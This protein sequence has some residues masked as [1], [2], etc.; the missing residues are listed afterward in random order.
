MTPGAMTFGRTS[1]T[2]LR[3]WE[4]RLEPAADGSL[5]VPL[6]FRVVPGSWPD[7]ELAG[8]DGTRADVAAVMYELRVLCDPGARGTLDIRVGRFDIGLVGRTLT[9]DLGVVEVPGSGPIEIGVFFDGD[10][11]AVVVDGGEPLGL[12]ALEDSSTTAVAPVTPNIAGFRTAT[13]P[14]ANGRVAI[15]GATEVLEAKI[16]GLRE[17]ETSLY[18]NAARASGAPGR[19][20]WSEAGY[21]V[22]DASVAV[23]G[24]GPPALVPDCRTIVSPVRV[25]EEF[26]WRDTAYGDMTRVVDRSEMWRSVVEP[27]RFPTFTSSFRSIDAAFELALETFQRNSSD[28]FS[29]PGETGLWSAGYF[30]GPGLGFGSWKRDTSHIALRAGNLIDPQVARASLA[31]VGHAGFDNGSD[32]ASLPAVA[33]WDHFLATGDESLIHDTWRWLAASASL[34]DE[35]FDEGRGLVLAAQSTSNDLFD[36]PEAGGYALSTEIYSMETYR[37][38]AAMGSLP[39]IGDPR[40][41]RWSERATTMR[42]AILA[43]YWNSERGYFTSG[44]IG[45]ESHKRGLWE[46]SGSEAAVWGFLGAEAESCTESV[47]AGM[48]HVAM[49]QYGV[50]LFPYKD[51]DN[52]FCHSVWYCWQAGFARAAARVGDASLVHQLIGQQARTAVLYKTF[53]EVTDARTGESW[54]WPGQLWHAAGFVSLVLFGLFGIRYDQ[55]GMTFSPA[56]SPEFDGARIYG[57]RYRAAVLDIEIRGH[58]SRCETTFD[59]DRVEQVSTDCTGRHSV[60]LTMTM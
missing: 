51:A 30:Q 3:V 59:G 46:T 27:G 36:E 25:I 17:A 6:R 43:Q 18:R 58:G 57:L 38:L 24:G 42:R 2:S 41:Q 5:T 48:R 32:G 12:L 56:V 10:A 15:G 22:S 49:S 20:F 40:A 14:P 35:R 7:I 31:H 37:V 26:V 53:Y 1:P 29:L 47:L 50:V 8:P 55:D 13:R 33:I 60:V 54:R 9:T 11:A 28:E 44:P 39:A 23:V 16:Y 45:S 21:I 4:R 19:P 52:H 34:L